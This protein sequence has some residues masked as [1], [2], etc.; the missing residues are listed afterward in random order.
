MLKINGRI[1]IGSLEKNGYRVI[2]L[3]YNNKT[4]SYK[5][6][7]LIYETISGKKIPKGYVIDHIIP[8][9]KEEVNN[10]YS[11]LRMCTHKENMNNELTKK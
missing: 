7:R 2:R 9:S 10:E 6:H 4:S 11:N 1:T 5:A 3:T 8:I